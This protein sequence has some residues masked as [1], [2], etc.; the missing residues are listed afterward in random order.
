MMDHFEQSLKE[1]IQKNQLICNG[2]SIVVGF[3]GGA[4]SMA[5]LTA[6]ASIQQDVGITKLVALHV[7]HGIREEADADVNFCQN[8]C[9]EKGIPFFVKRVSVVEEVTITH[10]TIEEAARRLRYQEMK[11]FANSINA[12]IAVA[13]TMSDNTETVLMHMVRGSGLHG[14][15]GIPNVNQVVVRPLMFATRTDVE[16]YCSRKGLIFV[17]DATND[18]ISYSRNRIRKNVIPELKQL[19][20]NL[21]IAIGRM[22]EILKE[23]ERCLNSIAN[24]ILQEAKEKEMVYSKDY[25][26]TQPLAIRNRMFQMMLPTVVNFEQH[27]FEMMNDLLEK[28]GTVTLPGNIQFIVEENKVKIAIKRK[29]QEAF[30]HEA[31]MDDP[32]KIGNTVYVSKLFDIKE[33]TEIK[34]VNNLFFNY[35]LDYDKI[36]GKI[37]VRQRIPGDEYHPVGRK[38]KTLKK[39]FN[40]ASLDEYVRE[41]LPVLID[42]C[43]IVM[44]YG[45]GCDERVKL[46]KETKRVLVFIQQSFT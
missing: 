27:H 14:L 46:S 10:E 4:D 15:T 20:S 35:C 41:S 6:L 31:I 23:D 11:K 33:F 45:F 24:Q 18:D 32:L 17:Q 22:T 42:D 2:D 13:H 34:K 44:V 3:S 21:D 30:F 29:K 39:L 28:E 5:L 36:I 9:K 43:G 26:L 1:Y 12:K 8:Y 38:G 25:F 19:N 37:Y 40:E 7:H 16:E